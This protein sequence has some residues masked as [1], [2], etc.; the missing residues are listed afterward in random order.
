MFD[1]AILVTVGN[2]L[3]GSCFAIVR[4]I[5][6]TGV[7][8]EMSY[9]PPIGTDLRVVFTHIYDTEDGRTV[10]DTLITG[11]KVFLQTMGECG[12]AGGRSPLIGIAFT[13]FVDTHDV[14]R[15]H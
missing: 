2:D 14:S 7:F 6:S 13:A 5:S 10:A 3:Y 4:A 9:T 8:L 15:V 12:A 1:K 11:G